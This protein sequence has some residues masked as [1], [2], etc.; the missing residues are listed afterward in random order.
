[1]SEP[2]IG[3]KIAQALDVLADE[4]RAWIEGER[5]AGLA[6]A[7]SAR[8]AELR[9]EPDPPKPEL[10]GIAYLRSLPVGTTRMDND[11]AY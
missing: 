8:A 2:L 1:M 3:P 6:D 5:Q 7:L 11:K 10:T 4:W 9:K